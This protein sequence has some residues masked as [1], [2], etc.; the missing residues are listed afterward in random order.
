MV[1]MIDS[2][3]VIQGVLKFRSIYFRIRWSFYGRIPNGYN[4]LLLIE[5]GDN[6]VL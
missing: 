1:L 6:S 2:N 3:T 4:T 5:N